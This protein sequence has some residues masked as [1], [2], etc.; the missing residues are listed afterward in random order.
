MS[1]FLLGM[2]DPIYIIYISFK[3]DFAFIISDT[4]IGVAN[5]CLSGLFVYFWMYSMHSQKK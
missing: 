1:L 4:G 2:F 3:V 5:F